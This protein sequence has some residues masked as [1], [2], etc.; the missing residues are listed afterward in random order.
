MDQDG[1]SSI[2]GRTVE[3]GAEDDAIAHGDG[4]RGVDPDG[5]LGDKSRRR[6]EGGDAGSEDGS[7]G[8]DEGRL[9]ADNVSSTELVDR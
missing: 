7:V 9:V 2:A 6:D 4:D 5:R 8:H 3:I 1:E